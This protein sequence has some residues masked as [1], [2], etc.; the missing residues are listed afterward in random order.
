MGVFIME[1][2][3]WKDV[4]GYEGLYKVSNLGKICSLGRLIEGNKNSIYF[5]PEKLMTFELMKKGYLRAK[6]TKEKRSIKKLVHVI[7][8]ECFILNPENKPQIN[9]KNGIKND[10]RVENLEWC[11]N[12]EN[13]IHA[14]KNKLNV[15]KYGESCGGSK[16][17]ECD[18]IEIRNLKGKLLKVEIAKK[19]NIS[20]H[21]I[22]Q[23]HQNISWRHLL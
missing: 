17:K 11:T 15:A 4:I 20:V 19:F 3:V 13:C 1:N 2:E 18:V 16:L 9:H 12:K 7:V 14:V 22:N 8:G 6:I 21:T 5:K 10:N 23:I